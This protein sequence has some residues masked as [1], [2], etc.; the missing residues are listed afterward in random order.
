MRA[1]ELIT[2]THIT[3]PPSRKPC[4]RQTP[5]GTVVV[6]ALPR[7][8]SNPVGDTTT[9]ARAFFCSLP[10]TLV[11]P[12][13]KPAPRNTLI[14]P[15]LPSSNPSSKQPEL[16][17]S[18]FKICCAC[19]RRAVLSQARSRLALPAPYRPP[20]PS[21]FKPRKAASRLLRKAG[22][23]PSISHQ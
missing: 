19:V 23:D 8:P 9:L 21:F 10:P 12:R 6:V 20:D 5:R 22:I 15:C 7:P 14:A 17:I 11:F 2:G 1:T 16:K 13:R 3:P 18:N 4:I